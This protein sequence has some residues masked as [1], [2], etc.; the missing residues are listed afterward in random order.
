M[1]SEKVQQAMRSPKTRKTLDQ[2][3]SGVS[4]AIQAKRQLLKE[5]EEVKKRNT[6]TRFKEESARNRFH[7]PVPQCPG[8]VQDM[9]RHLTNKNL[10]FHRNYTGLELQGIYMTYV[11]RKREERIEKQTAELQCPLAD[12]RWKGKDLRRHLRESKRKDHNLSK[13]EAKEV[14]KEG[15]KVVLP[16]EQTLLQRMMNHFE[17]WLL[18]S[19][20][21]HKLD[22]YLNEAQVIAKR[23]QV[24]KMQKKVH[25]IL[26]S[27]LGGDVNDI[28]KFER[29]RTWGDCDVMEHAKGKQE[30]DT[31]SKGTQKNFVTYMIEFTRFLTANQATYPLSR[32]VMEELRAAN[33]GHM[34]YYSDA[35]ARERVRKSDAK[36]KEVI[37][38][39][40]FK[41]FLESDYL[42]QILFCIREAYAAGIDNKDEVFEI[43]EFFFRLARNALILLLQLV[44]AKRASVLASIRY[45]DILGPQ[46]ESMVDEK[47]VY[48]IRIAQHKTARTKLSNVLIPEALVMT[49]RMFYTDV[50]GN[51][52]KD[53][54]RQSPYL[55]VCTDGTCF[56]SS[57]MNVCLQQAWRQFQER[58]DILPRTRITSTI[59]RRSYTT[60]VRAEG[61]SRE[62][63]RTLAS[64]LDHRLDTADSYYDASKE[65]VS[66]RVAYETMNEMLKLVRSSDLAGDSTDEDTEFER[67]V[68]E[69][70]GEV[71]WREVLKKGQKESNVGKVKAAKASTSGVPRSVQKQRL[72]NED[73]KKLLKVLKEYIELR[74]KGRPHNKK[75]IMA[76]IREQSDEF[77]YLLDRYTEDQIYTIVR[78]HVSYRKKKEGT[79]KDDNGEAAK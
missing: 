75:E 16:G 33:K 66:S 32:R 46:T 48:I 28:E 63:Q 11:A 57:G 15:R 54:V 52:M 26:Y 68:R 40:Q 3:L 45:E 29:V 31:A 42:S 50:K 36:S 72:W 9:A 30:G 39:K 14:A 24:Q 37:P 34:K 10:P 65:L 17:K 27:T 6:R 59:I 35:Y 78:A 53:E 69:E 18:S 67:V 20:G 79:G 49:L 41:A 5:G 8:L 77:N 22:D 61:F 7:C 70:M 19:E 1:A 43:Q 55:F 71:E 21:G 60:A 4:K 2:K 64:H 56:N 44:N 62:K 23:S 25:D 76:L 74:V 51:F 58:E 38:I 47:G 73:T 13:E 12:C